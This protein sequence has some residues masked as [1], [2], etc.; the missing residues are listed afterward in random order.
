MLFGPSWEMFLVMV[1]QILH[2]KSI[3]LSPLSFT[4]KLFIQYQVK[5]NLI[6][7]SH[8]LWDITIFGLPRWL[9]G[10]ESACQCR[11][12]KRRGFHP[13]VRK[14]PWSRRWQP[15]PVFLPGKF[16]GERSLE[17]YSPRGHKRVGHIWAL[18]HIIMFKD[19]SQQMPDDLQMSLSEHWLMDVADAPV[20]TFLP[21]TALIT[22]QGPTHLRSTPTHVS[23][24]LLG[25]LASSCNPF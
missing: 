13:W 1:S 15:T 4:F 21:W 3:R 22:Q 25:K 2:N 12:C 7:P 5:E 20:S 19:P 23:Q 11:R 9:S 16:H 18:T 17:G 10:K 6:S 14:I 24:F 8:L